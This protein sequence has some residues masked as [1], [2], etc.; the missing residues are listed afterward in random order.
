MIVFN[1]FII[2]FCISMFT[3]IN[4]VR[5]IFVLKNFCVKILR[6]FLNFELGTYASV[7]NSRRISLILNFKFGIRNFCVK[8]LIAI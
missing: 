8:I 2:L 6:N 7:L 5:V 3:I 1:I 4:R